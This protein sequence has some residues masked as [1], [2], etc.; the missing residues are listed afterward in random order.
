[1]GLHTFPTG[2]MS[3]A[4]KW[5]PPKEKPPAEEV[6]IVTPK[7]SQVF[8]GYYNIGIGGPVE[9]FDPPKSY[10]GM[11]NPKGSAKEATYVVP[12]GQTLEYSASEEFSTRIW[13]DATTGVVHAYHGKHWGN[14]QFRYHGRTEDSRKREGT[15]LVKSGSLITFSKSLT[16]LGSGFTTKLNKNCTFIPIA[17]TVYLLLGTEL[18]YNGC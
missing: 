11:A 15:C 12:T 17:P 2:Y 10:W 6:N 4:K 1:M 3:S 8:Y 9:V 14:W 18:F 7:I 13:E 5:L 16:L